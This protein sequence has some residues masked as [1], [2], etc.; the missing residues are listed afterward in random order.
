MLSAGRENLQIS[1]STSSLAAL[2]AYRFIVH[3]LT[4]RPESLQVHSTHPLTSRPEGL[5]V[6]LDAHSIT[7]PEVTRS[8]EAQ[9]N[10]VGLIT[11]DLGVRQ[12]HLSLV[13]PAQAQ[14]RTCS[15][16]YKSGHDIMTTCRIYQGFTQDL[17]RIHTGPVV[18]LEHR[19]GDSSSSL[20]TQIK[21]YK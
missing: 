21:I 13:T 18:F 12:G 11:P 9:E 4:G 7:Q 20:L 17:Y 15:S 2:K 19:N 6:H 16:S 1:L 5:Q 3:P 10:P 8:N 14:C